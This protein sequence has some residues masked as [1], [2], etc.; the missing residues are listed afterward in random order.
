MNL[1]DAKV[2]ASNVL[3]LSAIWA[4][5]NDLFT[6]AILIASLAYT[7]VRTANEVEKWK[8]RNKHNN[9]E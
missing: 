3:S 5:M 2:A 6:F 9:H 7:I 1:D 4:G 8:N